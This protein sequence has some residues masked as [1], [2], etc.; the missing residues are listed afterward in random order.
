MRRSEP[1]STGWRA[2]AGCGGKGRP[3]ALQA[4]GRRC[5]IGSTRRYR[6][7]RTTDEL[8]RAGCP[9]NLWNGRDTCC[10]NCQNP[11]FVSFGSPPDGHFQRIRGCGCRSSSSRKSQ[12]EIRRPAPCP[13]PPLRHLRAF[14]GDPWRCP[15]RTL[16]A[17][18]GGNLGRVR[19]RL[20][21]WL[22]AKGACRPRS[23]KTRTRASRQARRVSD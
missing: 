9:R 1:R 16:R 17:V 23:V 10:R 19:A 14:P 8:A 12:T 18:Q 7:S 5:V 6:A 21:Q 22:G 20:C 13:C 11:R 2:R 4:A 3:R 15:G